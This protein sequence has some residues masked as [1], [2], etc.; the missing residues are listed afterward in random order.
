MFRK[1]IMQ[2]M[3][4]YYFINTSRGNSMM[5][6]AATLSGKEREEFFVSLS[7]GFKPG[8]NFINRFR[9][10]PCASLLSFIYQRLVSFDYK[11]FDDSMRRY[12]VSIIIE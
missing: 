8:E 7:R 6:K 2:A 1:R 12:M 5:V 4:L 9:M 10:N 3:A 11:D